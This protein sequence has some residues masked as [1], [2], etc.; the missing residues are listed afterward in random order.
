MKTVD[1]QAEDFGEL[2]GEDLSGVT[3][4]RD[5]LQLQFNPP[6][7]LNAYT[8]VTVHCG[9]EVATFGD[10]SFPNLLIGQLNK[11]VRRVDLVPDVALTL[12]FDDGSSISI[13]LLPADYVGAEAVNLFCK[14]NKWV[15][16]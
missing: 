5:Y 1:M 2:I 6:P 11:F 15:V 13:S 16:L 10:A 4:V 7:S 14:N 9:Q 3:F 8:P 12:I